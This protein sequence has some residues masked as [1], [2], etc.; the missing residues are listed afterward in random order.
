PYAC[1]RMLP[2][3]ELMLMFNLGEPQRVVEGGGSACGE[4]HRNAWICG[5]QEE[6]LGVESMV[7]HPRGVA[8][9]LRPLGAWAL[10]AGLP[11]RHLAK[12]MIDLESVLGGMSGVEPL[13]QRLIAAPDLGVALDLLED[14]L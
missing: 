9:Q 13:R 10:F 8:V 3:G 5:R 6:P 1:H 4:V 12:E 11:L 2:N 7:R 14:W